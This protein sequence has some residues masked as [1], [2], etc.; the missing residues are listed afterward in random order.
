MG[1]R[2]RQLRIWLVLPSCVTLGKLPLVYLSFFICK[3]GENITS[4]HCLKKLNGMKTLV[5]NCLVLTPNAATSPSGF[6]CLGYHGTCA[7]PGMLILLMDFEQSERYHYERWSL[8]AKPV[9][10]EKASHLE[11]IALGT[12]YIWDKISYG[13][14]G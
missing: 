2:T 8:K 7:D 3:R 11:M 10:Q 1:F 4:K 13:D 6:P 5:R 9:F 14:E 12:S